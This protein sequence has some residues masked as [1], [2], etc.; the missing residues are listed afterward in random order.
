MTDMISLA[1]KA[2]VTLRDGSSWSMQLPGTLDENGIG[3]KDLGTN[4]WHPEANIANQTG[5]IDASELIQTLKMA[6]DIHR[7]A[8]STLHDYLVTVIEYELYR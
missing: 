2:K 3:Y 6:G 8:I 4:Q 7:N 5:E 1:G